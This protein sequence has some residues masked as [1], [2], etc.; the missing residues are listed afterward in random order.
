MYEAGENRRRPEVQRLVSAASRLDAA[1]IPA[2]R[3]E[4]AL[5]LVGV[6]AVYHSADRLAAH[7]V[8]VG[9]TSTAD[10]QQSE[11]G[12]PVARRHAAAEPHCSVGTP[13]A[14][15]PCCALANMVVALLFFVPF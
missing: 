4:S 10:C 13:E 5:A 3:R 6:E 2:E 15:R 8:A 9:Q 11:D 7:P 12:K 1:D 14:Q